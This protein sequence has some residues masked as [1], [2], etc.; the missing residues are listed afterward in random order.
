VHPVMRAARGVLPPGTSPT[1]LPGPLLP[2]FGFPSVS[3][4]IPILRF[5]THP[6]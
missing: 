2:C 4:F 1:Q 3:S 5:F 6:A